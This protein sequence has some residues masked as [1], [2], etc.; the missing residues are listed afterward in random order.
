MS[1]CPVSLTG[2]RNSNFMEVM[3]LEK[4]NEVWLPRFF[5]KEDGS[6]LLPPEVVLC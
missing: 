1:D 3:V 2:G 6:L 5:E 4:P